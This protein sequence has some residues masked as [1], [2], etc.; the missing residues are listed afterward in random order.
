MAGGLVDLMA[1]NPYTNPYKDRA[2]YRAPDFSLTIDGRD[3]T[4]T[5]DARLISLALS[6]CRGNESD[7]LDLVLNDSDGAVR[8]PPRG[9]EIALRIG[10]AGQALVDKGLFIV[11]EVEHSG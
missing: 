7:Q 3:I 5:I 1:T 4:P 11:D 6:E 2:P 10:W 8:L 9:A